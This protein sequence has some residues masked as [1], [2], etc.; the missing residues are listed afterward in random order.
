VAA[1]SAPPT[2]VTLLFPA[3]ALFTR[4]VLDIRLTI[5]QLING[6]LGNLGVLGGAAVLYA[7]LA[8]LHEALRKGAFAALSALYEKAAAALGC[9]SLPPEVLAAAARV[10][11]AAD[12]AQV[13]AGKVLQGPAAKQGTGGAKAVVA[14]AGAGKGTGAG[15]AA[16]NV[17]LTW[18]MCLRMAQRQRVCGTV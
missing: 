5:L 17:V 3:T 10:R 15:T 6:L 1:G 8:K 7:V 16:L 12:K 9:A 2:V 4:V 14:G 11:A 18:A 13:M